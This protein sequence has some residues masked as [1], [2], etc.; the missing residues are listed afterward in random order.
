MEREHR[1]SPGAALAGLMCIGIG[2]L[3]ILEVA[4]SLVVRPEV[5]WPAA[6]IGLGVA[7]VIEAV[8]RHAERP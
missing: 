1:F 3:F 7:L 5:L 6:I 4:G 2:L 8:V